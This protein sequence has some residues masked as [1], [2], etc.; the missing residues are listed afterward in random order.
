MSES[1]EYPI[2]FAVRHLPGPEWVPGLD[3]REQA[4]IGEHA[5]YW[6]SVGAEGRILLGGPFLDPDQG[7][8]VVMSP[9]HAWE[10]VEEIAEADPALSR[11]LLAYEILT[12][13]AAVRAPELE[14]EGIE[15]EGEEEAEIEA[16]PTKD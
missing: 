10:D 13:F 1:P 6:A 7:G 2:L 12:W 15:E 3:P 14:D 9:G 5:A 4:G 8:L 16:E 11:G